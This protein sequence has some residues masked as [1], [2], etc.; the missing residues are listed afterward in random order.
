MRPPKIKKTTNTA[1]NKVITNNDIKKIQSLQ[2]E[3][4]DLRAAILQSYAKILSPVLFYSLINP[5]LRAIALDNSI[6]AI[7][8]GFLKSIEE[9]SPSP[10]EFF[11]DLRQMEKLKYTNINQ[12][13]ELKS[14]TLEMA[15]VFSRCFNDLDL[16]RKL[17]PNPSDSLMKIMPNVLR[18]AK[19]CNNNF[20]QLPLMSLVNGFTYL[21]NDEE[22]ANSAVFFTLIIFLP[23]LIQAISKNYIAD[24]LLSYG[25]RSYTSRQLACKEDLQYEDA[26]GVKLFIDTLIKDVANL[27]TFKSKSDNLAVGL[28]AAIMSYYLITSFFSDNGA[29]TAII[30]N[31][32]LPYIIDRMNWYYS[33]NRINKLKNKIENKESFIKE[34]IPPELVK[35]IFTLNGSSEAQSFINIE[36]K[37]YAGF[38]RRLCA[39]LTKKELLKNGFNV[40]NF[41]DNTISIRADFSVKVNKKEI[42]ESI[43]NSILDYGTTDTNYKESKQELAIAE[44][45]GDVQ[46]DYFDQQDSS[47]ITE[48]QRRRNKPKPTIQEETLSSSKQE[49]KQE[50]SRVIKISKKHKGTLIEC[51]NHSLIFLRHPVD[52]KIDA[53]ELS[54]VMG[55]NGKRIAKKFRQSGIKK[56]R[57]CGFFEIKDSHTGKR[58][59]LERRK[60][61]QVRVNEEIQSIPTVEATRIFF[62]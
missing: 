47:R 39:Y 52:A 32:A 34:I 5:V 51:E 29:L 14:D 38:P 6:F 15:N 25:I 48:T 45:S 10:Q 30:I 24:P 35:E 17:T 33:Q 21:L 22:Q 60:N 50:E 7:A 36:I 44:H 54:Q 61:I 62:K 37:S 18:M 16:L 31:Q 28:Y 58:V 55:P 11:A 40:D 41:Q 23:S 59:F 53:N 3:S 2:N 57:G 12:Y 9:K 43:S 27:K 46:E 26:E 49:I 42:K 8:S 20:Y 1:T 13:M 56:L 19:Q 4:N